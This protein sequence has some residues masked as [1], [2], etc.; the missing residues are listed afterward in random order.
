MLAE[1]SPEKPWRWAMWE[2]GDKKK[3]IPR[4]RRRKM[5]RDADGQSATGDLG[6]CN[7]GLCKWWKMSIGSIKYVNENEIHFVFIYFNIQ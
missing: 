1:K 4:S 5:S 7:K 2:V 6:D 3:E